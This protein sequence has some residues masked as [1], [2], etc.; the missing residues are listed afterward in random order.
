MTPFEIK[1]LIWAAVTMLGVIGFVG[2]I[3]VNS[4][5]KMAKDIAEIKTIIAVQ[6]TKLKFETLT[7]L[8]LEQLRNLK[9]ILSK[10]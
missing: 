5:L 8:E 3:F 9:D 2:V 6:S 10:V 1:F 4:F 7:E